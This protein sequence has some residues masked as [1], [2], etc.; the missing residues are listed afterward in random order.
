MYSKQNVVIKRSLFC[1]VSKF[2]LIEYEIISINT[3]KYY[4]KKSLGFKILF[5]FFFYGKVGFDLIDPSSFS[6]RYPNN[7]LESFFLNLQ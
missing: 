7:R 5:P 1:T 4:Y 6:H 2:I 3:L